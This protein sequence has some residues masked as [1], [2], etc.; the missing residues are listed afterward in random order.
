MTVS[1]VGKVSGDAVDTYL[2]LHRWLTASFGEAHRV[3]LLP[4]RSNSVESVRFELVFC[5]L[6]QMTV[7]MNI[8]S[9]FM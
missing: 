4:S 5:F 2:P 3:V 6:F 8:R 1:D 7:C 9:R